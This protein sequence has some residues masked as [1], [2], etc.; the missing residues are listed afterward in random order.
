MPEDIVKIA[1]HRLN[2]SAK[3]SFVYGWRYQVNLHDMGLHK[4]LVTRVPTYL[5]LPTTQTGA[6]MT[7]PVWDADGRVGSSQ[8]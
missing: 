7:P 5:R 8:V 3:V 2:H 1:G 6:Q 4:A